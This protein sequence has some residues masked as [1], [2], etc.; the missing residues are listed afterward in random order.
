MASAA[1]GYRR[2][3]RGA[4]RAGAAP[5]PPG[6]DGVA[7]RA[8]RCR[9][10]PL[11]VLA[12][13]TGGAGP[14]RE[15]PGGSGIGRSRGATERPE[16]ARCRGTARESGPRGPSG[17][18]L[19]RGS[20]LLRV[21][22]RGRRP[23][24]RPGGEVAPSVARARRRVRRWR[25]LRR[26]ARFGA[27]F[28]RRRSQARGLRCW[29]C[30][31]AALRQNRPPR[32]STGAPAAYST[33][34]RP[35]PPAAADRLPPRH[36]APIRVAVGATAPGI[37]SPAAPPISIARPAAP[38]SRPA[39]PARLRHAGTEALPTRSP[40]P[41]PMQVALERTIAAPPRPTGASAATPS[42]ISSPASSIARPAALAYHPA[43]P[44]RLH[45]AG[46]EALPTRSPPPAPM[47][48]A[49]ERTI[50]AQPPKPQG[51]SAAPP[52]RDLLA[53]VLDRAAGG[54]GAAPPRRCRCAADAIGPGR[55]DTGRV[56]A[57]DRR[58]TGEAARR[59]RRATVRD[60][61]A[62]VVDRAAGGSGAAPSRRCR[63]AAGAIGSGRVH[64]GRVRARDRR[65]AAEA[66]RRQRRAHRPGSPRS[67]PRSR[68]GR[69]RR[70]SVTPV[71]MRCRRDRPQPRR[72][73]SRSSE[74]SPPSRRSRKAPA[75]RHRP[76]SPRPRPRSRGGRL[77]RRSVTP[78][79]MRCR[80]D[81][82]RPRRHRSRSSEG[83]PPSRRSRK[84]P[85]PRHRPGSPRPRRRSRG[86]RLRRRLR[87]AEAEALPTRSAPAAS[88]LVAFERGIA[89][90]PA[91][92]Q[93]A[94]AA[95]PSGISSPP[96]SIARRAA[97]APLRHAGADAL[98]TRSAPAASTQVAF[99]R[100]IAAQPPKPQGASAAPPSG[101]SS[102]PSSIARRAAPA[103]LRHAGADALPARSAPAAS[104][105]VAFERGI[106]AQPP[107]PQGA[108]AAPPSGISSPPSSIARRAA[109][110]RLRHAGAD[111]LPTRSAPAA[112]TR[113]AFERGIAAQ[114][115][116]PQG[117]S[118]A[119]P[120][121]ISSPPSS[122]ARRAAPAPLRHA[123]ADALP[124]RSAPAASTRVAFERGIATQPPKPQG[125]SAATTVRDLLAPV[126]DRAAGGSGAAPPRGG[127]CAA[128]A[129]GSSPRRPRSRSCAPPPPR[130]RPHPRR[131]SRAA[132]ILSGAWR[133]RGAC[134]PPWPIRC[135]R[136]SRRRRPRSPSDR[137]ARPA[138][139]RPADGPSPWRMLRKPRNLRSA[140]STPRPTLSR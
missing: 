24:P 19:V 55:V 107:K 50:A 18:R 126:V 49:L 85:A 62:P 14:A 103:P 39:S 94:S 73:R 57:R 45:P 136:A 21:R 34:L 78:V 41:A 52:S 64:T 30:R 110:A 29:P 102:P 135:H 111:A 31:R 68:G 105:Q 65:P 92:P 70:R 106:A 15:G 47:Q 53:P 109:P 69:L 20:R 32:R 13:R 23:P 54:P 119:S 124:A 25:T 82:S 46:T 5:T 26:R 71:P 84:A 121:G 4:R 108:S 120:S 33:L 104:T 76:G 86:G 59:Q 44:A 58:P 48:V 37:A 130:R 35:F 127:R 95:P 75:P 56:R 72:H 63:C 2:R 77:R 16:A 28:L 67:R 99:E 101:I 93:G 83:S 133:H 3:L 80:R 22:E 43:S 139:P 112:S 66:A 7:R 100:G 113:V 12:A 51:A 74:G 89:A 36:P 122:I 8:G 10:G 96:S 61:L 27:E 137:R 97:P 129:I 131:R 128:G 132:P 91:K 11:R 134:P 138:R 115:P 6:C 87:H 125:A 17:P 60:L 1:A 9:G 140:S 40:P 123:G 42:G 79:P 90:Q 81:R 38:A 114:P 88:T 98:P 118:A 116:K 117:A